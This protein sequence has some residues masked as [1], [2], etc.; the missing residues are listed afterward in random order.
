[1]AALNS[2]EHCLKL[3]SPPH[4]SCLEPA[5]LLY[6][7]T[8][9]PRSKERNAGSFDLCLAKVLAL[10]II[11]EKDKYIKNKQKIKCETEF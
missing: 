6:T 11:A 8:I 9:C 2:H 1:M 4:K 5:D 10:E 3:T 7:L